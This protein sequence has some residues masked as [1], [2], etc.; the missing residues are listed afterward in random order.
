MKMPSVLCIG[1]PH[2]KCGNIVEYKYLFDTSLE[3]IAHHSPDVVCVL[4]DT[5]HTHERINMFCLTR[6][7][8]YFEAMAKALKL[9][10][11]K[12][13]VLIGN[14]DRPNQNVFLTEEHAFNSMKSWDLPVTIVDK[15][16]DLTINDK[17]FL[18]MPYVPVGRFIEACDVYLGNERSIKEFSCVFAHQEFGGCSMDSMISSA[19]PWPEDYPLCV[20]GHIHKFQIP[21]DNLIYAGTP[22]QQ[23]YAEDTNKALSIYSFSDTQVSQTRFRL[24]GMPLKISVCVSCEEFSDYELPKD[25]NNYRIEIYGTETELRTIKLST[26]HSDYLKLGVKIIYTDITPDEFQMEL[27]ETNIPFSERLA[28][29]AELSSDRTLSELFIEL[30]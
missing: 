20:S 12:L 16:Y 14:H 4:G 24:I 5:L 18:F 25:S 11:S 2:I 17:S 15:G 1:D 28:K 10:G 30:F 8:E 6:A 22:Y 27:H 19:E 13:V 29:S 3:L 26:K 7:T 21:A 23:T 9:I